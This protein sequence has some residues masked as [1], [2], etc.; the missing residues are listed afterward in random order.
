VAAGD[1]EP[2]KAVKNPMIVF[3]EGRDGSATGTGEIGVHALGGNL[4]QVHL[5]HGAAKRLECG[6]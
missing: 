2:I 1:N 3:P 6:P 4:L 5:A